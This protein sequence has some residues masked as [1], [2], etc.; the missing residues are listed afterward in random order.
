[1]TLATLPEFIETVVADKVWRQEINSHLQSRAIH[2][3]GPWQLQAVT[4]DDVGAFL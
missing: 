4:A 3:E 1:M 2:A